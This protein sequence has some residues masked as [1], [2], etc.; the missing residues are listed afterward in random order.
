MSTLSQLKVKLAS[1]YE[2][3]RIIIALKKLGYEDTTNSYCSC[4]YTFN[5][6][7]KSIDEVHF[8]NLDSLEFPKISLLEL[9]K[10]VG[11]HPMVGKMINVDNQDKYQVVDFDDEKNALVAACQRCHDAFIPIDQLFE[12]VSLNW[13]SKQSKVENSL[14]KLA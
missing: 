11:T 13:N 14:S 8:D 10:K 9:E 3:R 7:I 4:I 2:Y 12:T 6:E 1:Y 5:D